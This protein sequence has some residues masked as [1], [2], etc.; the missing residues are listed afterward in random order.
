MEKS[1]KDLFLTIDTDKSG[2]LDFNELKGA[3]SLIGMNIG[4]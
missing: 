4:P 3:L 1:I 2:F